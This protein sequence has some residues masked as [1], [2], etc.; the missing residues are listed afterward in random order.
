VKAPHFPRLI[1]FLFWA[2]IAA[3]AQE[4]PETVWW[5]DAWSHRQVIEITTPD[6]SGSINTARAEVDTQG[7][8]APDGRDVRV[9][10]A[11]GKPV[12]YEVLAVR[13]GVATI[14]FAAEPK[15]R[16]YVV[17]YGNPR[18]K[19]ERHTWTKRRGGLHLKTLHNPGRRP[20]WS[21]SQ[22][23]ALLARATR[24]IGEGPRP[25]I[26]DGENPFAKRPADQDYY[27]S[28]YKGKL[29]CPED[30]WYTF[31]TNSDDASF[32]LIDGW[33]RAQI[34]GGSDTKS[35]W[36]ECPQGR[37]QLKRGVHT[38]EYY[39]VEWT[40]GQ[41]ARAGWRPPG[42][43]TLTTIAPR[44]FLREL[45]ARAIAREARAK[46]V[47]A[48]FS[49]EEAPGVSFNR[50]PRRFVPVAFTDRSRSALGRVRLR[51]WDF[52]D[53]SDPSGEKDPRHTYRDAGV[54]EVTLTVWDE[55]GLTDRCT[56]RVRVG[57]LPPERIG[58]YVETEADAA[59]LGTREAV[60]L[61]VRYGALAHDDIE[62]ETVLHA[63]DARG[64]TVLWRRRPLTL[65]KARRRPRREPEVLWT[66]ERLTLS[67]ALHNGSATLAVHY[68]GVPIVRRRVRV[69]PAART[70]ERLRLSK[71]GL[72]NDAGDLVLLRLGPAR[73]ARTGF[74]RRMERAERLRVLVVDDLLSPHERGR[75]SGTYYEQ[76]R[77]LLAKR[78]P[79]CRIEVR[80]V[81]M[82]IFEQYPPLE[83][84]AKVPALAVETEADLVILGPGISDLRALLPEKDYETYLWALVERLLGAT[85]AHVLL[86]TPPPVMTNTKLSRRY[87]YATKRVATRFGLPVADA[88]SA[89][90]MLPY[91]W[92]RLYRDPVLGDEVYYLCPTERGQRLIAERVVRALLPEARPRP[93]PPVATGAATA[94]ASGQPEERNL[95]P[96]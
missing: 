44:F 92:Q 41:L 24:V 71:K 40:G 7:L 56:R 78:F 1:P 95:G 17:Y 80:R 53:G 9:F 66:E 72:V 84:L 65:R 42:A 70:V 47:N 74:R 12:P 3:H 19:P 25:K 68:L 94:R 83:R 13:E 81:G 14:E 88:Y 87:A 45:Q 49:F 29:Y 86:I 37:V 79:R 5:N 82:E 33:L 76:A 89:F 50:D 75:N 51:R 69:Q 55:N 30:G 38:I 48:F 8:C 10:D 91:P 63:T 21:W 18:A 2:A 34:V 59:V 39:H 6:E 67:P 96:T 46:S 31:A 11:A 85:R 16:R 20:P 52:G 58:L 60:V 32:L 23:Q 26:D 36:D 15:M 35:S 54:Y 77:R 22:M 61:R 64:R 57:A 93:T 28:V 43:K 27:I 62:V 90:R 4:P 73:A